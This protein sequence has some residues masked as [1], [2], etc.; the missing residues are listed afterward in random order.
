MLLAATLLGEEGGAGRVLED[1]TDS[2]VGLRRALEILVCTNLLADLLTLFCVLAWCMEMT[3][4]PKDAMPRKTPLQEKSFHT[5]SG[6]T[7]FWLVL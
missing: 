7:G 1:L 4:V 3:R 5:C 6:V 2:L